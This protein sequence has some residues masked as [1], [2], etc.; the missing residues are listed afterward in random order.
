M[1]HMQ[2]VPVHSHELFAALRS[3]LHRKKMSD[4]TL[5]V[6]GVYAD[7]KC[8]KTLKVKTNSR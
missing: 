1:P 2:L 4:L 6:E 5:K 8:S 3:E 7:K